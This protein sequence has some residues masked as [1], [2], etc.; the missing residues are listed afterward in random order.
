MRPLADG[1]H[2]TLLDVGGESLLARMAAALLSL[3]VEAI[4][5]VTGYRAADLEAHLAERFPGRAFRWVH[6][7]G[8]ATT[9]NIVS[10]DLALRTIP[11]GSAVLVLEA[12]VVFDPVLL[13]RLVASPHANVALLAP[14]R[15]GLDGTVA[16]VEDGIVTALIP[17][18][19][20]RPREAFK[21]VNLYKLGAELCDRHLRGLL[22]TCIQGG[23]AE[24]YHEVVLGALV[25]LGLPSARLHAEVVGDE[26]WVEIDN[27]DDLD[28]AR[29]AFEP[30]ERRGRLDQAYGG[31]WRYPVTDFCY[32]RNHH[33]PTPAVIEELTERFA[34]LAGQYGSAQPVLDEALGRYLRQ[35]AERVVLLNGLSQVFPILRRWFQGRP[36]LVPAPTFGEYARA[37]PGAAT[38]ADA[39]GFDSAEVE[40]RA[41]ATAVVVFVNPNNPTGS[42]SPSD[43]IVAFARAHPEK[44]VLVDESFADFSSHPDVLSSLD[45]APENLVVLKSLGKSLGVSGLRLGF[46]ASTDAA[47]MA[48]LRAELP[49]WNVNAPAEAFL[50]L[51]LRRRADI[52]RSFARTRAD[53]DAFAAALADHPLVERA[54][55]SEANFILAR[56]RVADLPGLLDALLDR[57]GLYLKDVSD[58]FAEPGAWVRLAVRKPT[59]NGRLL[60]AMLAEAPA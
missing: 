51:L 1:A 58:R 23:G 32:P 8:Y 57:H 47:R 20:E 11:R 33:F 9:N 24:R 43:R 54:W 4:T 49:V 37:F 29:F 48:D 18:E 60:E 31:L 42:W 55:P 13:E 34:D 45:G 38:Y 22:E 21:T 6:N 46:A 12:D 56:L 19:R 26:A 17:G 3:G 25:H 28:H 5:I 14:W 53:R 36:A 44:T 50:R 40:A 52:A 10:L 39:V 15:P 27:P 35:P 16:T 7:P 30:L 59:D 41:Q 2:K